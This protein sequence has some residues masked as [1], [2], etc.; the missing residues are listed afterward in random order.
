MMKGER[1]RFTPPCI[2]SCYLE[3]AQ[4]NQK[5]IYVLAIIFIFD[6]FTTSTKIIGVLALNLIYTSI[7]SMSLQDNNN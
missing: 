3:C 2:P 1:P 5:T 6:F 7:N 4:C